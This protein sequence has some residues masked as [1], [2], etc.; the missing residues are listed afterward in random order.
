[1]AVDNRESRLRNDPSLSLS[2]LENALDFL[3]NG[4]VCFFVPEILSGYEIACASFVYVLCPF[5]C[6]SLMN[7]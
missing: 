1:M 2:L 6:A 7:P 5:P 3:A 4:S